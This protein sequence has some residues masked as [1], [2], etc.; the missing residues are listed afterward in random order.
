MSWVKLDDQARHHRKILAVGPT[1]A[2][3]WACG[4]MYC[5]AQK[6]RDG[7][8]PNEAV[9][10]LYP[11]PTWK[12]E[13][14]KLVAQ[15]LWEPVEGG[16]Q[17]HDYHDYQ[18]NSDAISDLSEKRAAAGRAGGRRSG[19]SRAS[20]ATDAVE[21]PAKQNAKQVASKQNEANA[22]QNEARPDPDPVPT[23]EDPPKG[24]HEDQVGLLGMAAPPPRERPVKPDRVGE[25]FSAYQRIRKQH[26][27]NSR[28]TALKPDERV[29]AA[30]LLEAGYSPSD[31]TLACEGVFLSPHHNGENDRG[32]EYLAFFH[33]M[34]PK[35]IDQLIELGRRAAEQQASM[36]AK[37]GSL[38]PLE[39]DDSGPAPADDDDDPLADLLASDLN[40]PVL[41]EPKNQPRHPEGVS[42]E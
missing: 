19:E 24:P 28:G 5:N 30:K 15:G 10:I 41:R 13:V 4:L 40:K 7:F 2:W 3:L 8:I 16:Y 14:P 34:S 18:P 9:Q 42:A 38:P 25:V 22:K 6:A 11:I 39:H 26:R 32:T 20:K 27:P 35:A 17:V 1:A 23:K 12:K 33:A 37:Y 31:L 29:R 21:A 36:A